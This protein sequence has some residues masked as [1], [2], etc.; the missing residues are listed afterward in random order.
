MHDP[1]AYYGN[2]FP[3][4]SCDE[5]SELEGVKGALAN[6]TERLALAVETRKPREEK[7]NSKRKISLIP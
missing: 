4:L 2:L 1:S 7:E 3:E 6:N 5:E